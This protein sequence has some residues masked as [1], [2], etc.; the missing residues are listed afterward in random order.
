MNPYPWL[1]GAAIIALLIWLNR[2]NAKRL[3]NMTAAE[4]A[5]ESDRPSHWV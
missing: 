3:R 4:H 2:W 1:F 5:E